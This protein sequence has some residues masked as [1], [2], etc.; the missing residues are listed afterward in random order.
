MSAGK[1]GDM[2]AVKSGDMSAGAVTGQPLSLRLIGCTRQRAQRLQPRTSVPNGGLDIG[3]LSSFPSLPF[4]S[5]GLSAAVSAAFPST[6]A[7]WSSASSSA[8]MSASASAGA[9]SS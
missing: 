5:V 8:F 1:S 6:S 2:S 3:S 7:F 9:T 4:A